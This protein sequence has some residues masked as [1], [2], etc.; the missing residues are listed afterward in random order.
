MTA[1]RRQPAFAGLGPSWFTGSGMRTHARAA[2]IDTLQRHRDGTLPA[3]FEL[4]QTL[5][6]CA[7]LAA[8]DEAEAAAWRAEAASIFES[9]GVVTAP[10]LPI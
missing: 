9:L 3:G 2:L 8:A 4:A 6:A 10:P 7:A 5:E 1:I